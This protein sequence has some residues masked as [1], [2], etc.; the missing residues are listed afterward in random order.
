MVMKPP[1]SG[2][3]AAAI[4]GGGAD[5][6]VYLALGRASEVAVDECLHPRQEQRCAEAT[7]DRP[8]DDDRSQ[9]L[10][11]GHGHRADGVAD[12]A[13]HVGALAT[14][15]V[16]DLAADQDEGGRDQGFERDRGLDAADRRV[17]ILDHGRDRH[18]HQRRVDHEHETGGSEQEAK[19]PAARCL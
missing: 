19:A 4:A 6:G 9:V 1:S 16:S 14:D 7:D 8:E 15:Q 11:E 3:I 5:Q 18:V 10:G 13:E 2:P 12:E 17:E